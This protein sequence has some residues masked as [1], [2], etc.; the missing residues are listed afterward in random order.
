M[1][2]MSLMANQRDPNKKMVGFFA[3]K[4]EKA[5]LQAAAKKAG[6]ETLADY[7]RWIASEQPMPEGDGYD[8]EEDEE[9]QRVPAF[10]MRL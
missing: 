8:E 2:D 6:F 3:T 1:G 9:E 10:H 5:L 7:L 4:D